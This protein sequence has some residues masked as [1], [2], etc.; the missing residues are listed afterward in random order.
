MS[1]LPA[2]RDGELYISQHEDSIQVGT[3]QWF[4]WLRE[5]RSFTFAGAAG[6]FTARHEERS[7]RRFWYAYRQQDRILRKTYLGRAA[8]LTLQRLEQAALTLAQTG[9][10]DAHARSRGE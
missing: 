9:D 6:T 5:A 2:V 1:R 10:Q 4:D 3:Q 8:D 7:G